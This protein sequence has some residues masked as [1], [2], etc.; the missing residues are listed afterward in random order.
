MN[1]CQVAVL[2]AVAPHTDLHHARN[3][4]ADVFYTAANVSFPDGL[5]ALLVVHLQGNRIAKLPVVLN[6]VPAP[7]V[8]Q[9]GGT[10]S[11]TRTCTAVSRLSNSA[12]LTLMPVCVYVCLSVCVHTLR[13]S[14]VSVGA[15]LWE[16]RDDSL[17]HTC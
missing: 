10:A 5:S 1:C 6:I 14:V 7:Q 17:R 3:K 12:Q 8:G 4:V 11:R 15:V 13:H 2:Y 16:D 9:R